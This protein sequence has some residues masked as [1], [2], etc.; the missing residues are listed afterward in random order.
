MG[1]RVVSVSL[2]CFLFLLISFISFHF[3]DLAV[4]LAFNSP[5]LSAFFGLV[6]PPAEK[7]VERTVTP[8]PDYQRVDPQNTSVC[9]IRTLNA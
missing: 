7:A 4:M 6:S 9:R 3:Y 5:T 2:F 8:P 1:V